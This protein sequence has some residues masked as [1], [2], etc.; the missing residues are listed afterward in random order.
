MDKPGSSRAR[1]VAVAAAGLVLPLAAVLAVALRSGSAAEAGCTTRPVA[2][3]AADVSAVA[4]G[5]EPLAWRVYDDPVDEVPLRHNHLHGGIAVQYGDRVTSPALRQI[6]DWYDADR[7]G[8]LVAPLPELG[9]VVRA[10]A[11]SSSLSCR[12]FEADAFAEFR[13]AHRYQGP[14][15]VPREQL[16]TGFGVAL[17]VVPKPV[18]Q[19]ATISFA[20]LDS[21]RVDV[22]IRD[23]SG[24]TVRRLGSFVGSTGQLLSLRWDVRDDRGRRVSP[25]RYEVVVSPARRTSLSARF[26][27]A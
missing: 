5:P 26:R 10:S 8:I 6:T 16:Q 9:E 1:L 13:D 2:R 18:G 20:L 14:E 25:G 3:G 15:R 22:E 12:S 19:R 4:A 7:V 27:V 17:R 21:E 24:R 23:G 11:W